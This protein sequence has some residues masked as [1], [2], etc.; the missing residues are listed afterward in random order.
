[1]SALA[2][3]RTLAGLLTVGVLIS[4]AAVPATADDHRCD[5][6]GPHSR[7]PASAAITVP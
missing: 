4:T 1:M 3:R 6:R 5:H 7:T 2:T